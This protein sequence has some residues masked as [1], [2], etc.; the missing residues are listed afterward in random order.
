VVAVVMVV[1]DTVVGATA[2]DMAVDT[3]ADMAMDT[4]AKNPPGRYWHPLSPRADITIWVPT[5]CLRRS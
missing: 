5:H 4:A 2:V 1:A 3:L